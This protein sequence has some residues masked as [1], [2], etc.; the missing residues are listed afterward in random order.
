MASSDSISLELFMKSHEE[1]DSVANF[2]RIM[3][4]HKRGNAR[5]NDANI[6]A[7]IQREGIGYTAEYQQALQ[8]FYAARKA[9]A[10]TKTAPTR[11]C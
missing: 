8:D 11:V 1:F 6:L 2:N 10:G 7:I 3:E 9:R 5:M 4:V